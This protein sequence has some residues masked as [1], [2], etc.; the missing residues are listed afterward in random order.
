MKKILLFFLLI[1]SLSALAYQTPGFVKNEGKL[2]RKSKAANV[3]GNDDLPGING[4][5]VHANWLEKNRS[6]ANI[7]LLDASSPQDFAAGHIP[8]AVN[9]NLFIYGGRELPVADMEKL[10][11]SW[12]ISEGKK[13]V[14]YDEGAGMMATRFFFSL[15]YHG[16]AAKDIF[17]LDGGL[18][19]WKE[20]GLP[21][22]KEVT[23]AP[24]K[25]T[26]TIRKK[27]EEARVKLPEFL[28]AS[29][30]KANHVLLEALSPEWHFGQVAP[31]GKAGHIPNAIMIPSSDFYNPDKTFKSAADI[32]KILDYY[33]IHPQ[34][35]INSH[36]GGGV[37][38]SVP[39]FAL[40]FILHY[41]NVKLYTE[42]QLGWV[43]DERDL[44]Y[45]TYDAPYLLRETNWLQSWGGKMLRM[46]GISQVSVLDLR[47]AGEFYEGHVPYA[48]NIPAAMFKKNIN[49]PKMLAEI[50]GPAGVDASHEAVIISGT[51]ITKESALVFALLEQLGQKKISIFID[52]LNK[53]IKPGFTLIKDSTVVGAKKHPYDLSIPP[54]NYQ[55]SKA[56]N[57]FLTEPPGAQGPYPAVFIAS[58]KNVAARSPDGQVIH[59]P[60]TDL[61]NEN[62]KPKEAKDIW[63][64]LTKAGVPRY[65]EIICFSDDAGEAAVNYFMFKLMGYPDIKILAM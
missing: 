47:S 33:G 14:L 12:G 44:P 8:G 18:F 39:F 30:D 15:Y 31:F 29:G 11:Q 16:F 25:G 36:C 65:A 50:L 52:S 42:S 43:S 10:F 41:P 3:S 59:V 26:F 1:A 20:K 38:A 23:P 58:G 48:I 24:P 40:K 21:L 28:A 2:L 54:A 56:K 63:N 60:Y 57:I 53:W 62:G 6:N 61:L 35:Q 46:Y 9:V 27:Y 19:K 34:Q 49:N 22:T 64:I 13:V 55:V 4:N 5:L 45:W 32:K 17:I 51:G 37:A 7:L